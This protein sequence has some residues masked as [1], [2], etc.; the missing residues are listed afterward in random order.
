MKNKIKLLYILL[1]FLLGLVVS[2]FIPDY[3]D[4]SKEQD[5]RFDSAFKLARKLQSPSVQVRDLTEFQW[6][7]VCVITPYM[8]EQKR[9]QPPF[10]RVSGGWGNF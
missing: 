5:I 7:K 1:G 2:L 4:L 6:E 8:G 9:G 10:P 3:G